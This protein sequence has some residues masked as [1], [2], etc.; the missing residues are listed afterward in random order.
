MLLCVGVLGTVVLGAGQEGSVPV[1]PVPRGD[2]VAFGVEEV[3]E[4]VGPGARGLG[5]DGFE[6]VGVGEPGLCG[7]YSAMPSL[8]RNTSDLGRL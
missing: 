6:F 7:A 2:G 4:G 8:W 3:F 5:V 1:R